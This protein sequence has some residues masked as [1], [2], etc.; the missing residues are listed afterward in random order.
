MANRFNR[1]LLVS[2]DYPHTVYKTGDTPEVGMAYIAESLESNKINY[3]VIDMGLGY[4]IDEVIKKFRAFKPDLIG[5]GFKSFRNHNSYMIVRELKKAFPKAKT[6]A[7]GAHISVMRKGVL[8]ELPE[9]DLGLVGEGEKSIVELCKGTPFGKIPGLVYRTTQE[10]KENAPKRILDLD[11]LHF[12]KYKKFELEKYWYPVRYILTSR[13]CPFNCTFCS[14]GLIT[15]HAWIPR[16]PEN[17]VRE[18]KYWYNKGQRFFEFVDDNFTLSKERAMKILNLIQTSGLNGVKLNCPNG[19]RADKVDRELLM[20]MQ[21][22]G[23]DSVTFGVEVGNDKMMKIIN[24][25]EKMKDIEKAIA[26]SAELGLNIHLVFIIGFPGQ[27][28][29]DVEDAF[30]LCEKY[31]IRLANFNNLIPYPGTAVYD[32]CVEKGCLLSEPEEYLNATATKDAVTVVQ[33]K[34]LPEEKMNMLLRKAMKFRKRIQNK[35]RKRRL[36]KT[37]PIIRAM[38]FPLFS[39][40]AN[41]RDWLKNL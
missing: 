19:V 6:I 8:E 2:V 7:G 1:V 12:P 9:L 21:E 26:L 35:D 31:P 41:T 16:S 25:S 32:E 37:N 23:F 4:S 14:V 10:I 24:K 15:S 40:I 3:R 27:T 17:V 30:A 28:E 39:A 11:S 36:E 22:T 20:K 13:G 18:M 38:P 5:I 29:K 33:T 34:E